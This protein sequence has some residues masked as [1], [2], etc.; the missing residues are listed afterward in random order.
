MKGFAL[1]I[2][3]LAIFAFC[4]ACSN[5]SSTTAHQ[6]E[7]VI[8]Y[9]TFKDRPV[10]LVY[11]PARAYMVLRVGIEGNEQL[12]C[13][14]D[15]G[16]FLTQFL[17]NE[18]KRLVSGEVVELGATGFTFVY[19]GGHPIWGPH[20]EMNVSNKSYQCLL[21]AK[22]AK[23]VGKE[24]RA[25]GTSAVEGYDGYKLWRPRPYKEAFTLTRDT[26]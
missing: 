9:T 8:E 15:T 26:P 14:G 11:E 22:N 21:F 20:S 25:K 19:D 4:F 10:Q 2:S 3:L 13:A 16:D 6:K 17:R 24:I 23:I 5:G 18:V 1:S 12:L 7:T